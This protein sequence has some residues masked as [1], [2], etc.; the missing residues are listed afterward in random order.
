MDIKA[1]SIR[2]V[3]ELGSNPCLLVAIDGPGGAGKSML[4]MNLGESCGLI[5]AV[6][7]DHFY[8]PMAA[9][10][11]AGLTAEEGY[12]RYFDWTRM[13]DQLLEPLSKG[14]SARYQRYDWGLERL[15][16]WTEQAAEGIVLVD[17]VYSFRP[18]LRAFY[19][20]SIF[21]NS[22]KAVCVA[23]L[24]QRGDSEESIQM[25]RAAEDYYLTHTDPASAA[26]IVVPGV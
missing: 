22:P 6:Q 2:L 19:G 8:T 25:W 23:R 14:A 7:G 17:G 15:A 13:R 3:A 10:E 18:E 20:Y 12:N 24:R 9:D 16:E 5:S 1:L 4:A 21:V 26:S 11:R